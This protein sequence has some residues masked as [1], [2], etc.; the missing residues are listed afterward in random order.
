[1]LITGGV[2]KSNHSIESFDGVAWSEDKF[3]VPPVSTYGHCL[4][5]I[6]SSTLMQIGGNLDS[7][8]PGTTSQTFFF[9]IQENKWF[10]GK[11]NFFFSVAHF[12]Y[13]SNLAHDTYTHIGTSG[14]KPKSSRGGFD[15]N[16]CRD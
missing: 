6:N 10:P 1:M 3:A 11:K 7:S 14:K 12:I 5:K 15:K 8:W 13:I 16:H 9:N 2:I 4:V